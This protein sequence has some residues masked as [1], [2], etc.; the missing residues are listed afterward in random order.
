MTKVIKPK[1]D[2]FYKSLSIFLGEGYGGD[3]IVPDWSR[4]EEMQD[5]KKLLTDLLTR[6]IEC[7]IITPKKAAEILYGEISNEEEAPPDEY[8]R[9]TSL[10]P[11]DAPEKEEPDA[12][13][14]PVISAEDIQAMQEEADKK[15][16]IENGN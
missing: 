12:M 5:D 2:T 14:N 3:Q 7:M 11:V 16:G 15:K 10:V 1:V 9:K 6:Q 13:G 8:F 4:V